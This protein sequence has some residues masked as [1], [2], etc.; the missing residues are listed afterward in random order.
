MPL[1]PSDAPALGIT[2]VLPQGLPYALSDTPASGDAA[3]PGVIP[4]PGITPALGD[5][6]CSVQA[7]PLPF[8]AEQ[9]SGG[10]TAE[11]AVQWDPCPLVLL[12]LLSC[13]QSHPELAKPGE[14]FV[15]LVSELL[16]RLLDYRAVMNDE[17]KTYSM[18]CTVNLLVGTCALLQLPEAGRAHPHVL[19]SL[20]QPRLVPML[21]QV[22]RAGRACSCVP[23]NPNGAPGTA[24]MACTWCQR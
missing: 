6:L 17:N 21:P 7:L 15:K 19:S 23:P 4:G 1:V 8:G 12:S 3:A 5:A 13:C 24:E 16:E 20:G 14:D 11:L 22:S 18:S 2:L 9:G 10:S